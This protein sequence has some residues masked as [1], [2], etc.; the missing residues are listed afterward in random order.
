MELHAVAR[1]RAAGDPGTDGRRAQARARSRSPCASAGGLGSL[2]CACLDAAGDPARDRAPSAPAGSAGAFNLNFFCHR[3][4]VRRRRAR[5]HVAERARTLLP[6]VRPR[7]LPPSPAGAVA[8]PFDATRCRA[9]SRAAPACRQLPF[10]AARR[11]LLAR[12]RASGA[13]ILA[14]A[15]TVDEALWLER[16]GVDAR[17]RAGAR[18]GRPSRPL[19][20]RRSRACTPA[21][22][23]CVPQLVRALRTPVIAAGGI[24][25]RAGVEAA[26]AARRF[27]G[28]GGHRRTSAALKRRRAAIHRRGVD[29]RC[30]APHG[31]DAA[32]HGPAGAR[33]RQP[34]D[35][36]GR[37]CQRARVPAR[38]RGDRTAAR[39]RRGARQRSTSRR[40]GAARTRAGCRCGSCG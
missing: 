24:A 32:D 33:H 14:S 3:P 7:P 28:P 18:G 9:R 10:R 34:P 40:S 35:A 21:R 23:R 36:R 39:R 2:P 38:H 13:R 25:D 1:R 31:A 26:L 16:R 6:R 27:D 37:R 12:V 30:G 11:A 4:P 19:P 29:E 15:T 5:G 8:Y 22:S 20:V 17:D